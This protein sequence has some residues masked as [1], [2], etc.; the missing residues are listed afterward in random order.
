MLTLKSWTIIFVLHLEGNIS[1]SAFPNVLL[2]IDK[3]RLIISWHLFTSL[4]KKS[5]NFGQRNWAH[6]KRKKSR[7]SWICR[8]HTNCIQQK[9]KSPLKWSKLY[10]SKKD[11]QEDEFDAEFEIDID[12]TNSTDF[13]LG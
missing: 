5:E 3:I 2:P 1:L 13:I 9:L 4:K 7:F 8:D 10:A 6:F 12:K 11:A